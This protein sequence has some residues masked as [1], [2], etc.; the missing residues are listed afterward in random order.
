MPRERM[1]PRLLGPRPWPVVLAS[2]AF[3]VGLAVLALAVRGFERHDGSFTGITYPNQFWEPFTLALWP[4]GVAVAARLGWRYLAAA[5]F[6]GYA[7]QSLAFGFGFGG[8]HLTYGVP[9]ALASVVALF[10]RK[11]ARSR[12]PTASP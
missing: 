9:L 4:L 3:L 2:L 12:A 11:P 7:A 6:L 5:L 1:R 8:P 10:W